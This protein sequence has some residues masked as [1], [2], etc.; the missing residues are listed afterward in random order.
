VTVLPDPVASAPTLNATELTVGQPVT[1]RA[2]VSGGGGNYSYSWFG[3]PEGCAG[4][5]AALTCRP[6]QAGSF[7]ISTQV[8]DS[9]GYQSDSP[10][11]T[12]VVTSG[13]PTVLGMPPAEFTLAMGA[14][15][16]IIA[17]GA[18]FLPSRIGR[19]P[20]VRHAASGLFPGDAQAPPRRA[21]KAEPRLATLDP[22]RSETSVVRYPAR[23]RLHGRA[24]S[25]SP[26]LRAHWKGL[27]LS[28]ALSGGGRSISR[29]GT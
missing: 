27:L 17:A 9:N 19:A 23:I 8:T 18:V 24:S 20:R 29:R 3:L 25:R 28:G 13:P 7:Y 21:S 10:T 16:G 4:S 22:D 1:I 6:S 12:L 11:A 2:V 26:L 14:A 15:A 5:G